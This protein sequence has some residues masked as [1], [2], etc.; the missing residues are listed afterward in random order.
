MKTNV[1]T[2]KSSSTILIFLAINLLAAC[3]NPMAAGNKSNGADASS[4]PSEKSYEI[5]TVTRAVS[6][7]RS[8]AFTKAGY[9]VCA[10]SAKAFSL[11]VMPFPALPN[12]YFDG[13]QTYMSDGVNFYQKK[14]TY[15]L[16]LASY[17]ERCASEFKLLTD[18][19][20]VRG[21]RTQ[22]INLA[23][24]GV[25]HKQFGPDVPYYD[26]TALK[27]AAIEVFSLRKI[28]SGISMRCLDSTVSSMVQKDFEA[29]IY[30]G[31][32]DSSLFYATDHPIDLFIHLPP[33]MGPEVDS[34][35]VTDV[36]VFKLGKAIDSKFFE[37]K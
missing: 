4:M 24:D 19:T 37:F 31:P 30:D 11:P 35:R 29:C 1:K 3:D 17:E 28:K 2:R 36:Q 7:D 15:V 32:N 13:R 21:N 25:E 10:A 14:E 22:T 8:L 33:V 9:D 16:D 26:F 5:V 23:V 12:D 34:V 27:K 20:I 18:I 6:L